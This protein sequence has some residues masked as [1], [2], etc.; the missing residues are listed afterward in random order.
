M[1]I[2]LMLQNTEEKKN[3]KT[4]DKIN[5]N[6]NEGDETKEQVLEEEYSFIVLIIKSILAVN[7]LNCLTYTITFIF[8]PVVCHIPKLFKLNR[9]VKGNTVIFIYI[10]HTLGRKLISFFNS[11]KHLYVISL[12]RI[13]CFATLPL[14]VYFDHHNYNYI[15]LGIHLILNVIFIGK[16]MA[17]L[18][19]L[20]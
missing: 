15:V 5:E 7:L 8:F 6:I 16:Q 20:L 19:V 18:I 14:I 10:Y 12:S 17:F 13:I 9:K 1:K 2:L 4:N 3:L 11:T